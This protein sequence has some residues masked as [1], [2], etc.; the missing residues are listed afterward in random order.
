MSS[1]LNQMIP[2]DVTA[3]LDVL[4]SFKNDLALEVLG[5]LIK[6]PTALRE[7]SRLIQALPESYTAEELMSVLHQVPGATSRCIRRLQGG[8]NM[9]LRGA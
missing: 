2:S 1:L 9:S 8:N 4:P 6:E 5:I 7:F 3:F